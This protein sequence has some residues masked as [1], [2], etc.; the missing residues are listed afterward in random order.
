[1]QDQ[2]GVPA[3]D[4]QTIANVLLVIGGGGGLRERPV[5]VPKAIPRASGPGVQ[6]FSATA[7]LSGRNRVRLPGSN[8][9]MSGLYCAVG[10]L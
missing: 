6:R 8:R 3:E 9:R 5:G 10:R 4:F 7:G 1:M 2:G